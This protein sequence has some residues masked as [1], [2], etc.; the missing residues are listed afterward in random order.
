MT[1]NNEIQEL[2]IKMKEGDAVVR[3][4]DHVGSKLVIETIQKGMTIKLDCLYSDR[5]SANPD[6]TIPDV[7]L[8][9]T[10]DGIWQYHSL[11]LGYQTAVSDEEFCTMSKEMV[12]GELKRL[13]GPL[14]GIPEYV[15]T[16]KQRCMQWVLNIV[17][18]V[19]KCSPKAV[20]YMENKA[21]AELALK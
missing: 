5:A 7:T 12:D 10:E 19:W 3:Y 15:R 17:Q 14:E 18:D 8:Q 21:K 13:M 2:T 11:S 1:I 6:M 20:E 4:I 9:Q 16:D